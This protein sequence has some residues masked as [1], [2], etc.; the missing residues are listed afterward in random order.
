MSKDHV[1][2]Y[3]RDWVL[4][5][6]GDS[7]HFLTGV[8]MSGVIPLRLFHPKGRKNNHLIGKIIPQGQGYYPL[9]GVL[10]FFSLALGNNHM[11]SSP[12]LRLRTGDQP[13]SRGLSGYPGA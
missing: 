7:F 6:D 11:T 8:L 9:S 10:P 5:E 1:E 3:W 2:L 13:Y 4:K 12:S